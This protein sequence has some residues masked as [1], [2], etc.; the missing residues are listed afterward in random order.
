MKLREVDCCK[1]ITYSV[2]FAVVEDG[3]GF[4]ERYKKDLA[5]QEEL[6]KTL[7]ER[8]RRLKVSHV[9][10]DLAF[11]LIALSY[12]TEFRGSDT[13]LR[14]QGPKDVFKRQESAI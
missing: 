4:V 10:N 13:C 8:Q 5:A 12:T 1:C 14:K 3:A 11:R 6:A 9:S 7:Q 2:L